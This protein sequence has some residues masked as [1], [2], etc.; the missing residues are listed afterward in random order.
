[1]A[2]LEQRHGW[3]QKDNEVITTA[4]KCLLLLADFDVRLCCSIYVVVAPTV[5]NVGVNPT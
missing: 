4:W 5:V 2:Q 1:M 3:L